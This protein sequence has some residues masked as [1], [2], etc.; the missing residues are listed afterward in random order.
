MI[1]GAHQIYP[2]ATPCCCQRSSSASDSLISR[3]PHRKLRQPSWQPAGLLIAYVW[4]R[5]GDEVD[6]LFTCA[7][8]GPRAAKPRR[9]CGHGLRT[10]LRIIVRKA[11]KRRASV[12]CE[13]SCVQRRLP[14][15]KFRRPAVEAAELL[16]GCYDEEASWRA[17]RAD[18]VAE[19]ITCAEVPSTSS[20]SLRAPVESYDE[21]ASA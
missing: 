19:A 2:V 18:L 6:M 21:E 15:T 17:A 8:N 7:V 20:G 10:D 4:R 3:Y 16:L 1:A 14:A 13:L 5:V 12:T 9:A 11:V